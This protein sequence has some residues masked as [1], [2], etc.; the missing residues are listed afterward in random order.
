V[1]IGVGPFLAGNE[2]ESRRV[3]EGMQRIWLRD[4]ES[5]EYPRKW[6]L[7]QIEEGADICFGSD[8]LDLPAPRP[9]PAQ[10]R[11]VGVVIRGWG[12]AT[13]AANFQ[14]AI[15]DAIRRLQAQGFE[16]R[17]FAF[18]EPADREPVDYFLANGLQPDIW[19]P[20]Q[21]S[22][23]NYLEAMQECDFFI[24]ARF[25]GVVIASLLGR[26]A[27]GV[28][29]DPKVRQMCAKLGLQDFV[30]EAPFD[31]AQLAPLVAAMQARWPEV[32][33]TVERQRQQERA[34]ADRMLARMQAE[35]FR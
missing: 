1:G 31:T 11:V 18:C 6:G 7:A 34:A 24:T 3:L 35:V 22:T 5:T 26:P 32:V 16:V 4:V 2:N 29:V 25:H 23:S 20:E 14:V 17:L 10:P 33:A 30:W 27:I 13:D 15:L 19:N 28:A 8:L 12:Y 9:L 21:R